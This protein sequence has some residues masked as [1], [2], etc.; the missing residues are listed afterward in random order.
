MYV[1]GGGEGGARVRHGL[2]PISAYISIFLNDYLMQISCN[3]MRE[4]SL[5]ESIEKSTCNRRTVVVFNIS[6]MHLTG[7]DLRDRYRS[8]LLRI[9]LPLWQNF[10][11]IHLVKQTVD[12]SCEMYLVKYFRHKIVTYLFVNID[13]I[14]FEC[15]FSDV[16]D[17]SVCSLIQKT[18]INNGC[19]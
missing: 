3:T 18:N 17:T 4:R 14:Y 19:C 16:N 7:R 8:V 1:C 12:S 13:L 9:V 10:R 2:L 15:S 5:K 6:C 11:I